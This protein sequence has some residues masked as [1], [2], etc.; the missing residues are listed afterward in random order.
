MNRARHDKRNADDGEQASYPDQCAAELAALQR[1]FPGGRYPETDGPD[2]DWH[3]GIVRRDR[4]PVRV[5]KKTPPH[6]KKRWRHDGRTRVTITLARVTC[7]E[8]A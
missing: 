3:I 4:K 6:I 7:L 5:A 1:E 2:D 8:A